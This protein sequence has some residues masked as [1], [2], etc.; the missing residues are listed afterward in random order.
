MPRMTLDSCL[1]LRFA[2]ACCTALQTI[3]RTIPNVT[4][5][6]ECR[7]YENSANKPSQSVSKKL[8]AFIVHNFEALQT[9]TQY[10]TFS[11]ALHMCDPNFQR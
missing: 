5:Y 4:F 9:W 8:A 1:L 6:T 7:C 2:I 11:H 3:Y 10:A